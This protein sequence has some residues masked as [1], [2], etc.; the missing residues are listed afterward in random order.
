MH[1]V[2]GIGLG[3]FN[4]GLAALLDPV[5]DV[6]DVFLEARDAIMWHPG[7]LLPDSRL[8]TPFM[9]DLVTMADPTSRHSFLQHLKE[10]GRLYPF[11]IRESF[12]PLRREFDAYCRWVSE[13]LESVRLSRRVTSVTFDENQRAY[14]V[15]ASTPDGEET[16]AARSL[17]VGTGTPPHVPDSCGGLPAELHNSTYLQRRAALLDCRRVVVVGSGQSAAEI[18]RDLLAADDG[19]EREVI[20]L[21]RSPRFFPLEY[22]KL[23]LE[24]TSPE[25]VDHLHALPPER[26]ESL[27][28]SQAQLYKGISGD[29]V[30]EIYD[31]LYAAGVEGPPNTRLFT[32]TVVTGSVQEP[33][34]TYRL[35]VRHADT[36]EERDLETDGLVLA[37]GYR[38][39]VPAFLAPV[40]DRIR[41]DGRGRFDVTRDYRVDVD[42]PP[43][44]VQN[45]ELHT[46]GF[47]APDLGMAAYR[48]SFIVRGITGRE[49]YP[50]ETRIAHQ[51]FGLPEV[52]PL[53]RKVSA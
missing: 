20:W 3:P 7:M 26:R 45:A 32:N 21:T 17:V 10:T 12:Y 24:M 38:H 27:I 35:T 33:D 52:A 5:D 39:E 2:I 42:G 29:L 6:D 37:T 49:V 51:E 31:A 36:G 48:N 18:F 23:T 9:S 8:Q 1:D 14:V 19:R 40:A 22:T 46:H 4:L 30:D 13:R 43:I 11:Y 16:Y 50:I 25:Y 44:W 53:R 15:R 41:W 28:T 47:A 34:G